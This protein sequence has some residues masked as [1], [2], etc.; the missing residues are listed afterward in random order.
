MVVSTLR[1]EKLG[2]PGGASG[3]KRLSPSSYTVDALLCCSGLAGGEPVP[4]ALDAADAAMQVVPVPLPLLC[5][6]STLR[7]AIPS[8]LRESG[9]RRAVLNTLRALSQRY[10]GAALPLLHPVRDMGIK[11]E[12]VAAAVAARDRLQARLDGNPLAKAQRGEG[13]LEALQPLREKAGL[14][15]EAERVRADMRA[16][17]LV[18]FKQEAKH[19]AAVLRKLGHVDE[20]GVVTMKA[21][22]PAMGC[23]KGQRGGKLGAHR[24][25][26]GRLRQLAPWTPPFKRC[27]RRRPADPVLSSKQTPHAATER[28]GSPNA[29]PCGV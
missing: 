25:W 15:A 10:P 3:T 9:P 26:G 2:G 18:S 17:Q 12:A 24:Q 28:L 1:E 7:V 20:N 8:D 4:A 11:G 6:I 14:M 22:E 19:R 29:G 21:S 23:M 16:S 27:S 13:D 5:G